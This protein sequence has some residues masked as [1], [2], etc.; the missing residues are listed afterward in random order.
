MGAGGSPRLRRD[1]RRRF[2]WPP[3]QPNIPMA[4]LIL[5]ITPILSIILIGPPSLG[6][7]ASGPLSWWREDFRVSTMASATVLRAP[8]PT[9]F[10]V[11]SDTVFAVASAVGSPLDTGAAAAVGI[12]S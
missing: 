12:I 3:R 10:M 1:C 2:T 6:F 7:S 9:V 5:T 11:G 4:I 8:S